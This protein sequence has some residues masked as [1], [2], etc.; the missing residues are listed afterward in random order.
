MSI[1]YVDPWDMLKNFSFHVYA[2][3]SLFIG[4]N[5]NG[6][7]LNKRDLNSKDRIRINYIIRN[8]KKK[9]ELESQRPGGGTTGSGP[10]D[11][12]QSGAGPSG[13]AKK[14][15]KSTKNIANKSSKIR[16]ILDSDRNV[17]SSLYS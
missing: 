2:E 17:Y 5:A 4:E 3:K 11:A 16:G 6:S 1:A 13:I 7:Q 10:S 9:N 12:V 14:V 15:K 8:R